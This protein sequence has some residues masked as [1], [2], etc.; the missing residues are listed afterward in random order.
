[1]NSKITYEKGVQII[2]HGDWEERIYSDGR[3]ER[4]SFDEGIKVIEHFDI[5]GEW[6]ERLYPSGFVAREGFIPEYMENE[7]YAKYN[8]RAAR[9]HRSGSAEELLA[10][11]AKEQP[12]KD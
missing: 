12:E 6:T 10:Q 8:P 11:A 4:I 5:Q 3:K 7:F 9:I 2:D 1:M